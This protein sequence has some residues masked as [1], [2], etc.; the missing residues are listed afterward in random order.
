[1]IRYDSIIFIDTS[2]ASRLHRNGVLVTTISL[3]L[4]LLHPFYAAFMVAREIVC[5]SIVSSIGARV[6]D[7]ISAGMQ[8]H[9]Y[10]ATSSH[11]VMVILMIAQPAAS[12]FPHRRINRTVTFVA[13]LKRTWILIETVSWLRDTRHSLCGSECRRCRSAEWAKYERNYCAYRCEY[14]C[15]ERSWILIAWSGRYRDEYRYVY[16]CQR[17]PYYQ[18]S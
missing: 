15:G 2:I 4:V 6:K 11:W 13:T 8:I 7:Q 5:H 18:P 3:R 12:L 14:W 9:S 17:C 16:L 10:A 1:M